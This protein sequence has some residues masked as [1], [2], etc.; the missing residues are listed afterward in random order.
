MKLGNEQRDIV[1]NHLSEC[2]KTHLLLE[3]QNSNFFLHAGLS[4]KFS[5]R[6]V[7]IT[8]ATGEPK[9]SNDHNSVPFR[10]SSLGGKGGGAPSTVCPFSPSWPRLAEAGLVY[11]FIRRCMAP[12]DGLWPCNRLADEGVKVT[13]A[14]VPLFSA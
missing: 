5:K 4:P 11:T 10:V 6:C 14:P 12:G 3:F 9:N 2:V 1:E 7:F 8:P 13:E